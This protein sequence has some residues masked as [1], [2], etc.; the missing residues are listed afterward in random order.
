MLLAKAVGLIALLAASAAAGGWGYF[1]WSF[2]WGTSYRGRGL[3][4]W[5]F[6][7]PGMLAFVAVLFI[8]FAV[9]SALWEAAFHETFPYAR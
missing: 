1:I 8:V 3:W 2:D 6:L 5:I 7:L 4:L 9:L